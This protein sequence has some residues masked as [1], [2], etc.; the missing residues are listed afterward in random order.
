VLEFFIEEASSK[1]RSGPPL[2]DESD[3]ALPVWAG[4]LPLAI[5][6]QQPI[7]EVQLPTG[8]TVPDYVLRYDARLDGQRKPFLNDSLRQPRTLQEAQK[9]GDKGDDEARL[10]HVES[11]SQ[12]RSSCSRTRR[13]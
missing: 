3:H 11:D 5:R 7:S 10:G 12:R 6:P 1:V 9:W 13:S 2:E 4:V 8:V